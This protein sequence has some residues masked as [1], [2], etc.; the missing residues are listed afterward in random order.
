MIAYSS[1]PPESDSLCLRLFEVFF[2]EFDLEG[3]D[4]CLEGVLF[5]R[6][7]G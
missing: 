2:I 6:S 5:S 4:M 3:P 1:L 7:F